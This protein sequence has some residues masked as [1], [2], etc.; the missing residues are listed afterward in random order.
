MQNLKYGRDDWQDLNWQ[1]SY[2]INETSCGIT[3]IK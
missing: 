2:L 3:A 1:D